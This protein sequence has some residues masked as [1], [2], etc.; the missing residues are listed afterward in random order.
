MADRELDGRVAERFLHWRRMIAPPDGS[1]QNGGNEILIPPDFELW[2]KD[3]YD[4]PKKGLLPLA[5]LAP[6]WSRS[7]DQA[8]PL[9]DAINGRGVEVLIGTFPPRPG[10]SR[11]SIELRRWRD[12]RAEGVP[13][14]PH[15]GRSRET[16]ALFHGNDLPALICEA[17]LRVAQM[18]A[19][20]G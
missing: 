1:G 5:F 19:I 12:R 14:D 7:I 9:L 11:Y 10:T 3:G 8:W 4:F 16:F 20:R 18:E 6:Q 15:T 2:L 13:G 17:A